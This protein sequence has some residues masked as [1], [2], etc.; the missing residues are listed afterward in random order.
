L[1]EQ[2]FDRLLSGERSQLMR[3]IRDAVAVEARAMGIDIVDVRI[4]ID[5][6]EANLGAV[7][8]QRPSSRSPADAAEAVKPLSSSAAP[9]IAGHGHPRDGD[10]KP[11]SC[12]ARRSGAEPD[13]GRSL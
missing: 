1:G 8:P 6:P 5:L 7:T 12:A 4:G 13:S 11:T 10:A 9:P 3:A 2:N